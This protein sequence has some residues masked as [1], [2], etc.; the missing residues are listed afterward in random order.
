ME[1]I[2]GDD[3]LRFE[4]TRELLSVEQRF[5]ANGSRRGIFK[6]I[7]KAFLRNAYRSEEEAVDIARWRQEALERSQDVTTRYPSAPP[8]SKYFELRDKGASG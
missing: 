2:C 5:S 7:E 4:L 1:E 6:E 3:R 8:P